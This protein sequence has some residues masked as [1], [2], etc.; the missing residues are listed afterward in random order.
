MEKTK[1]QQRVDSGELAPMNQLEWLMLQLIIEDLLSGKD[2]VQEGDR[3]YFPQ[4]MDEIEH[5]FIDEPEKVVKFK[6]LI[7]YVQT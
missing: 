4:M 3:E 5:L 1:Y 6:E 7:G 2:Q